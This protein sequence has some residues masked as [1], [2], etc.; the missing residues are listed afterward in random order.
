MQREHLRTIRQDTRSL[1][2]L[3]LALDEVVCKLIAFPSLDVMW[4]REHIVSYLKSIKQELVSLPH[5]SGRALLVSASTVAVAVAVAWNDPELM[6]MSVC[7]LNPQVVQCE[8]YLPSCS[9]WNELIDTLFGCSSTSIIPCV[10]MFQLAAFVLYAAFVDEESLAKILSVPLSSPEDEYL[11]LPS[12]LIVAGDMFGLLLWCKSAHRSIQSLIDH[13]AHHT[14]KRRLEH[15]QLG[16]TFRPQI[17][18][19]NTGSNVPL[20]QEM[21]QRLTFVSYPEAR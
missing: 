16:N 7:H 18:R 12:S 1:I 8:E 3:Q 6:I 13:L 10:R 20:P 19:E 4:S 21:S 11:V 14:I 2:E 15:E 5:N 17:L 9:K